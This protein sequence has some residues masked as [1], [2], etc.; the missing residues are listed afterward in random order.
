MI[1][2]QFDESAKTLTLLV[3]GRFDY[4]CQTAFREAFADKPADLHYVVDLS[5]VEYMDS[6]ALGML[7]LLRDHS[8]GVHSDV[9]IKGGSDSV[10]NVLR[11]ARFER[12]FT[13]G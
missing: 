1:I 2:E 3:D 9:L 12:L 6:S 11:M 10:K 4:K 5:K 7:F 13:L 8:G